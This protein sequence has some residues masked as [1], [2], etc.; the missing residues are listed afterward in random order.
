MILNI[1]LIS[2]EKCRR[3]IALDLLNGNAVGYGQTA[4]VLLC[5]FAVF[6][7]HLVSGYALVGVCCRRAVNDFELVLC[8]ICPVYK[9]FGLVC[10]LYG[11]Y[12]KT[13]ALA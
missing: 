6:I 3:R 2:G 4:A 8:L 11:G 5:P 12:T 7:Q 9:L 1:A 10:R 13:A